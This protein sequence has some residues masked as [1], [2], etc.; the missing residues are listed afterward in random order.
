MRAVSRVKLNYGGGND[1]EM[2][3]CAWPSRWSICNTAWNDAQ[4][5]FAE[6][7]RQFPGSTL[8][9]DAGDAFRHCYWSALMAIYFD[10][11]ST[12]KTF[13]D[14]HEDHPNNPP[15]EKAMDLFN[16]EK[17]RAIGVEVK[18]T[19]DPVGNA[20]SRCKAGTTNGLLQTRP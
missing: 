5:A 19:T 4:T 2:A 1:A 13:G 3:F 9:N 11:P 20:I 14:L 16:N 10:S 18:P 12:A 17:G 7:Q 6:A 8:H 15:A